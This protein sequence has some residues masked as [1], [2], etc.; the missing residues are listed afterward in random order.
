MNILVTGGLGF[1]GINVAIRF[2]SKNHKV[3]VFDNLDKIGSLKNYDLIS[4]DD[5]SE[6]VK[7]DLR[8]R[9]DVERVFAENHFDVIFHLGGQTAVTTSII[10][11]V[12]DFESNALGTFYVL[13]AY[14]KYCPD[15]KLIFSSS[16]KVFGTLKNRELIEEDSRY[17]FKDNICGIDENEPLDFCTPYGN[18]KGTADQYIRDYARTYGLDTCVVIQSCIY[19]VHQKGT[20]SQGW[21]AWFV[22]CF[23]EQIPI[24]IYGDGKQVRDILYISDLVDFYEQLSMRENNGEI[25]NLGGGLE[26]SISLLELLDLLGK[27]F[28]RRPFISFSSERIGD[29]KI[30]ISNNRKAEELGWAPKVGIEEGI[31]KLI[32]S[33][34]GD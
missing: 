26:N 17:R 1:I 14:R 4:S 8:N 28:D 16:N 10:D 23:L 15:A 3:V 2:L 24:T 18:S 13:E 25:Y 5:N 30:F 7:G 20:E 19:G 21:V 32:A 11:P 29:Q 6:F 34:K 9:N 12:K 22:R 31:G 27:R 33:L